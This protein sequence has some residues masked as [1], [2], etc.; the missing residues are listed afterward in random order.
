MMSEQLRQVRLLKQ[1]RTKSTLRLAQL[2]PSLFFIQILRFCKTCK[3]LRQTCA[4][5]WRTFENVLFVK[6]IID[7]GG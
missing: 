1:S 5:I 2:Q 4:S 6:N 7:I 3:K